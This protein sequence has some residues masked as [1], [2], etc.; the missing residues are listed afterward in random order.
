MEPE[1]VETDRLR[2]VD[3]A[4]KDNAPITNTLL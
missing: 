4:T 2:Y 1:G 3:G